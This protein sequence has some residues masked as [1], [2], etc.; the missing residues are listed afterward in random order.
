MDDF[1]SPNRELKNDRRNPVTLTMLFY[2]LTLAGI[3]A[4]CFRY[5]TVQHS[6]SQFEYALSSLIGGAF[7]FLIG[8]SQV[9]GRRSYAWIACLLG[10]LVGVAL[11]PLLRIQM[12]HFGS[13]VSISC[14][15]SWILVF[16][17]SFSART[18]RV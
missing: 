12:I 1:V 9:V 8:I 15:G 6:G 11:G 18:N 13:I 7:G 4:A 14:V 16:I 3:L 10:P 5:A 17:M 2:A